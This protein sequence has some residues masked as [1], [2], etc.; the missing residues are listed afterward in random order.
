MKNSMSNSNEKFTNFIID[1]V[2]NVD[3]ALNINDVDVISNRQI[4]LTNEIFFSCYTFVK[5][6]DRM[7]ETILIKSYYFLKHLM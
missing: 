2:L 1:D 6:D 4:T 7:C 3:D 5:N